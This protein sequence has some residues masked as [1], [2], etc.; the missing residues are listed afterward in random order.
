MDKWL[1]NAVNY[2]DFFYIC[3]YSAVGMIM[4]TDGFLAGIY[5]AWLLCSLSAVGMKHLRPVLH[6]GCNSRLLN[7]CLHQDNGPCHIFP[8]ICDFVLALRGVLK[9][10]LRMKPNRTD[11]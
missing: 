10:P 9:A 5:P 1:P 3:T 4:F 8:I 7:V 2:T 6:C 11:C